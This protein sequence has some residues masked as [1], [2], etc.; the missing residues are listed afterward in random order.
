MSATNDEV[1]TSLKEFKT[2]VTDQ[3]RELR[4]N[5]REDLKGYVPLAVYNDL[6]RRVADLEKSLGR[7]AWLVISLVVT[8]LVG[9][10]LK[11]NYIN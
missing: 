1:L 5:L 2:E 7:V 8:A 3:F 6:A 9:L 10:V 11:D 4:V